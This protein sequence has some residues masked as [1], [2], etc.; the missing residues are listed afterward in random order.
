MSDASPLLGS[1]FDEAVAYAVD[2]H[3]SQLRKE[4]DIPYVTHLFAVCSLVLEDG[5]TETDAIAA[6]LHDAVEDQG[7]RPQLDAIRKKFGPKVAV[8]VEAL[9][10]RVLESGETEPSWDKRKRAYLARLAEE[11]RDVLRISLADKLHNARSIEADWERIGDEV[12][13]RFNA[14]KADQAWYF[15]ELAAIFQARL[16]DSRNL[17][18]FLAVVEKLIG[19]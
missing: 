2:L 1:K 11:P 18:A 17:P 8:L 12:Y 5:G 10:D 6:L 16:P 19:R 13:D 3:R 4:S 9:S 14:P 15:G 7:G